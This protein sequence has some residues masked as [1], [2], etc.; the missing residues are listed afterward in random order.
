MISLFFSPLLKALHLSWPFLK[1]FDCRFQF[2]NGFSLWFVCGHLEV[3][4]QGHTA[5]LPQILLP[6]NSHIFLTLVIGNSS[7][8][9]ADSAAEIYGWNENTL[10]Q[11]FYWNRFPMLVLLLLNTFLSKTN[12][13]Q[14][15]IK[16]QNSGYFVPLM[17]CGWHINSKRWLLKYSF[18]KIEFTIL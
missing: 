13:Q 4:E 17:I 2:W 11:C 10:E 7:Q 18:L 14:D 3:S 6:L 15:E 5:A 16:S 1:G 9:T 12:S 8:N